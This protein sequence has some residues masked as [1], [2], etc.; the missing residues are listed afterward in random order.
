MKKPGTEVTLISGLEG[1]AIFY[2]QN[3]LKIP[4][5]IFVA[6]L[7]LFFILVLVLFFTLYI[8]FWPFMKCKLLT[9]II[10][11]NNIASAAAPPPS[12]HQ[13]HCFMINFISGFVLRYS[14]YGHLC[15]I[16]QSTIPHTM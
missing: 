2:I 14:V 15:D 11:T 8:M 16:Q 10:D 13:P 5:F 3:A 1:L 4:K 9:F 6:Q 12:P 7:S